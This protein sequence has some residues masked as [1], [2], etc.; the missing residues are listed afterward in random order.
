MTGQLAQQAVEDHVNTGELV[1]V[2]GVGCLPHRLDDRTQRREIGFLVQRH[3]HRHGERLQ[4]A[5]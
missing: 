3:R 2:T 5:T 1:G 4:R